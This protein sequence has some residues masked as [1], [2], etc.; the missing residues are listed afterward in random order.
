MM[1]EHDVWLVRQRAAL[2]RLAL[3]ALE[4]ESYRRRHGEYPARP[5]LPQDPYSGKPLRY[6]PAKKLYSV[7]DD[8]LG[9]K[10]GLQIVFRL[11]P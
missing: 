1:T 4:L 8:Y 3:T 5:Q 2:C 10:K 7:G 6:E 9:R 11:D